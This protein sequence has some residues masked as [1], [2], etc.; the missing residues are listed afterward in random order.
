MRALR[1]L[2]TGSREFTD[3][4]LIAAALREAATKLSA[5][6]ATSV[7]LITGGAR[8]ADRLAADIARTLGWAVETHPADW[9]YGK[10]AGFKR[11]Q[12]MVNLGADVCIALFVEGLACNGTKD[13][14]HRARRAGITVLPFMQAVAR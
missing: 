3:R 8:G 5:D 11:N 13:C 7:T 12:E 14:A 1:I 2:L 10:T 4:D 9:S 6:D